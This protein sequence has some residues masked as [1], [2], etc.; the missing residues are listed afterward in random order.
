MYQNNPLPLADISVVLRV[1]PVVCHVWICI[2]G[3]PEGCA[4]CTYESASDKTKCD[5]G[6][7]DAGFVMMSNGICKGK[8]QLGLYCIWH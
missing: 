5:L 4:F 7:C 8:I 6:Q 2:L 3:C 1:L